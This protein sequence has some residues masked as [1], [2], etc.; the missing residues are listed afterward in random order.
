[1]L[2]FF[3]GEKLTYFQLTTVLVMFALAESFD[4]LK[5]EA[6]GLKVVGS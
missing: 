3:N 5:G 1:M 4:Q 6:G 2:R